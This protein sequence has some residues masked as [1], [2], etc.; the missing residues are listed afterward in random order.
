MARPP[1]SRFAPAPLAAA[2]LAALL[3][4]G[5]GT[6]PSRVVTTPE[7]AA[8]ADT[9][10]SA[11]PAAT[12]EPAPAAAAVGP[13]DNLNAVAW[14]QTSVEYRLMAG[15]TWRSALAQLDKALK[16]P[17]WDALPKED[18][19]NVA[20]GL[21]PA[22]IVDVDETVLDNSPYQARLIRDRR[23][24]DDFTWN[25]WVQERAAR[26]IPGAVEFARA[27]AARGVTFFYISNRT[28]DQSAATID[29]LRK[30][31]FPVKDASQ[32]LGLGTV[33]DGCESDGSEKNCRRQLVGR[34]HR[35]LMQV[36]DQLGDLVTVVA[37]TPDGREQ[38]V[39]PY[40]SWVGERWFVLP[41][42]TYGSWEPALFNN[43]WSRPEGERRA[44]KLD[45][46]RY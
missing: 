33:V 19:A 44:E 34:S 13:H 14:V 27:A 23:S 8:T 29:N 46:L 7:P 42:P 43:A 26:P 10:P 31:G 1:R 24:F 28:A 35:V 41:N 30:A 45:A 36:G 18:R 17:A 25:E 5:C 12:P 39:R 40:L 3:L 4:G 38:A 21:P 22:I 37:N 11:T 9:V 15:Q 20:A 32:F 6:M 16:A 2:A